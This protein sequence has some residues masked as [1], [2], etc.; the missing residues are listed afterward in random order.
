MLQ[1]ELDALDLGRR[2]GW[3]FPSLCKWDKDDCIGILLHGTLCILWEAFFMCWDNFP[4]IKAK[5][6]N[7][8]STGRFPTFVVI[9]GGCKQTSRRL[10]QLPTECYWVCVIAFTIFSE[11][12]CLFVGNNRL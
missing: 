6:K 5:L 12:T 2:V 10:L 8:F 9:L 3:D 1:S 4:K 7:T 11:C